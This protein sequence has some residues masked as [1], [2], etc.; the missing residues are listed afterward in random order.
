MRE[1]VGVRGLDDAVLEKV[2]NT[3]TDPDKTFTTNPFYEVLAC[4]KY[5][6]WFSYYDPWDLE[7]RGESTN[8]KT[9][10]DQESPLVSTALSRQKEWS[11]RVIRM[12]WLP[13]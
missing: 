5:R 12:I 11:E 6:T 7:R 13:Y 10:T 1:Q 8:S 3:K 4:S 9:D 2:M